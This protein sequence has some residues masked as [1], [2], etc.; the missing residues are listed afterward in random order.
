MTRYVVDA[1]SVGPLVVPDEAENL[2]PSVSLA[3]GN[4]EC[5]VPAHWPFEVGN[6]GLTAVRRNRASSEAVLDNLRDLAD[7]G[8]KI[9]QLSTELSWNRTFLLAEQHGLSLYDAAYLELAQRM[10]AVL[11]TADKALQR[12]AAR[13]GLKTNP[14]P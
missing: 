11:L 10:G 7:F 3:L 12:A 2:M 1:S 6:L 4:G 9:D 8:I 5:I 14:T 13:E